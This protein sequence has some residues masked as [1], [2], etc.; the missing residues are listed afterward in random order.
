MPWCLKIGWR[1]IH[2]DL[3]D[4]YETLS[5]ADQEGPRGAQLRAM[6]T[7]A[8]MPRELAAAYST[9]CR[10]MADEASDQERRQELRRMATHLEHVPWEPP[11]TFWEAVQALWLNHM[12]IMSDENYPGPGV[13]FGRIDQYLLPYWETS[14]K[15]GMDREFGK[16]I[17]KCF[18]VHCNTVYDAMIRNGRQGI[19]AGFGQLITLSGLGPDGTG[20]DQRS[21]LR[22]PGSHRRDVP[23][24]GTQTQCAPAPQQPDGADGQ[25][26]GHDF[27][28]PGRPFPAQFR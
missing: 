16:E 11:R 6:M 18:W 27:R 23:H 4:R 24:P 20:Y 15:E 10:R 19:T 2:A 5:Q 13:S 26:R 14:L 28:Q 21:D 12:L 25:G 9:L 1:G 22:H 8:T 3:S 7:A 17:L